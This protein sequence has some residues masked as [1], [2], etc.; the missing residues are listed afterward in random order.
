MKVLLVRPMELYVILRFAEAT[1]KYGGNLLVLLS[2]M[3]DQEHYLVSFSNEAVHDISIVPS[4]TE[5]LDEFIKQLDGVKAVVPAGEFSVDLADQIAEKLGLFHTSAQ[6]RS[7]F[8]NK[9]KMRERFAQVG[10]PQPRVIAKF[11]S[12]NAVESWNWDQ[13]EFP[14]IVKPVDLSASLYVKMCYDIHDAKQILRRIFLYRKSMHGLTFAAQGMLEEVA[15]GDEYSA[16]CIII[17]D[18]LVACFTTRKFLSPL[19]F[20]NEVGHLSGE[21]L[22]KNISDK[23]HDVCQ[24]AIGAMGLSNGVAHVEFK[25]AG[26]DIKVIEAAARVAGDMISELVQLKHGISLEEVLIL[27]RAGHNDKAFE[28]TRNRVQDKDNIYGIRFVFCDD[29]TPII[30]EHFTILR[31]S[32]EQFETLTGALDYN[33]TKRQGYILVKSKEYSSLESFISATGQ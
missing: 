33:A 23:I 27:L 10:V 26:E 6:L 21:R 14:V 13:A 29:E 19:P 8:R 15:Q 32:N 22:S 28:L 7:S 9:H 30:P 5:H 4:P 2:S 3:S 20:C 16:E 12:M 25:L 24:S 1:R 31:R 18:E 11:D 17:D